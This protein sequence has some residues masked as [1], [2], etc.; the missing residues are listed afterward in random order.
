MAKKIVACKIINGNVQGFDSNGI[1]VRTLTTSSA[2]SAIA[3]GDIITVTKPN[4]R[5][6]LYDANTGVIKRIIS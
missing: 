4:G 5:I 2:I 6:E 3:N 1:M